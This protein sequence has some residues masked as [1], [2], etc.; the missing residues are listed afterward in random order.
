MNNAHLRLGRLEYVRSSEKIKTHIHLDVDRYMG[1]K[2]EA[3]LLSVFGGDADVGAIAAAV[4]ENHQ[5][6]LRFPDGRSQTIHLGKDAVCYRAGLPLSGRK[7]TLRHLVC[8]SQ[9]LHAN[10]A[11]G[12]TYM[13]NYDPQRAWATLVSLLGLPA[14]PE[15]G[16]WLLE[17]LHMCKIKR[18]EGIGCTPV[19]IAATRESLMTEMAQGLKS[20]EL[21]FP[22]KNGPLF[23]PSF[24]PRDALRPTL[25]PA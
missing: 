6:F 13:L 5:M 20:G 9:A 22:E 8:V 18:L 16:P 12:M 21:S 11:A 17:R 24:Q 7:H 2:N 15:W 1:E 25:A 14:A 10:G 3:H 23:W 4:S 19:V